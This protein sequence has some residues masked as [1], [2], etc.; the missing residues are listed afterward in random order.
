MSK[1]KKQ[2]FKIDKRRSQQREYVE[3]DERTYLRTWEISAKH[4]VFA[5]EAIGEYKPK[6]KESRIGTVYVESHYADDEKIPA[7]MQVSTD[8]VKPSTDP[9]IRDMLDAGHGF[10]AHE[11]RGSV[12]GAPPATWRPT[13]KICG[14]PLT[15]TE[16]VE[17]FCSYYDGTRPASMTC[18]CPSCLYFQDYMKGK[19]RPRG[20]RPPWYCKSKECEKIRKK[21]EKRRQRGTVS[22]EPKPVV[23]PLP[24]DIDELYRVMSDRCFELNHLIRERESRGEIEAARRK[25]NEAKRALGGWEPWNRGRHWVSPPEPREEDRSPLKRRGRNEPDWHLVHLRHKAKLGHYRHARPR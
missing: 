6:D 8:R 3:H 16:N 4:K 10:I 25:L 12:D 19:Y 13:C 22:I 14:E 21:L 17:W 5:D 18:N 11:P 1:K 15:P 20:G 9:G 7:H 2:R 23:T 24:D